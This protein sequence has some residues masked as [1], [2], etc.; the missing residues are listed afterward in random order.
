MTDLLFN[1]EDLAGY[2]GRG[3]AID[4][5]QDVSLRVGETSVNGSVR[6]EGKVRGTVDGVLARFT[7]TATAHKKCVRCL[8][9]WDEEVSA[10]GE[11]HFSPVP[12]EDGYAIEAGEVNLSGPA[13]DELS[14]SLDPTP[15]HDPDCMGLCP[16]C[17]TDLNE[18]RCS[19]H[20]E[21]SDSPF[22]VLKDLFIPDT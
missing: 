14:L 19:G 22:A 7:S 12:D 13:V 2:L 15:L 21:G 18:E 17:G 9:E 11:Q 4:G 16:S 20:D 3:R 8:R 10:K 1:V 6:V 5:F